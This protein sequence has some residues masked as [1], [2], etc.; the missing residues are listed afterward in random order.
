MK[1]IVITILSMLLIG[2]G[3]FLV[4]DKFIKEETPIKTEETNTN[5][6]EL[7]KDTTNENTTESESKEDKYQT[8]LNNMSKKITAEV[9]TFNVTNGNGTNFSREIYLDTNGSLYLID[10]PITSNLVKIPSLTS[11]EDLYIEGIKLKL[12][13]II[14]IFFIEG[15]GQSGIQTL[16]ALTKTGDIYFVASSYDWSDSTIISSSFTKIVELKNIVSIDS[17]VKAS[18]VSYGHNAEAIDINGNRFNLVDY[19][20]SYKIWDNAY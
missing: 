17:Y 2:L 15:L 1:N 4:Y 13:N 3:G 6:N 5:N 11:N 14:D 8:Y 16:F 12:N 19:T 10:S 7:S 18:P 20:K 9:A